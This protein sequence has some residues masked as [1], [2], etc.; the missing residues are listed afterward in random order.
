MSNEEN[1]K[2]LEERAAESG[3]DYDKEILAVARCR[4]GKCCAHSI[5][6]LTL[7]PQCWMLMWEAFSNCNFAANAIP[8]AAELRAS[9]EPMAKR[10]KRELNEMR[11]L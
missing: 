6:C 9:L 5:K 2:R 11:G 8:L 4:A 10:A 7:S 1:L 3:S